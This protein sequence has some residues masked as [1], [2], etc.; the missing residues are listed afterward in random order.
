MQDLNPDQT[1]CFLQKKNLNHW[2]K[3]KK[4]IVVAKLVTYSQKKKLVTV[5]ASVHGLKVFRLSS[6]D[7]DSNSMTQIIRNL[8]AHVPQ[9]YDLQ[10][11]EES[12]SS[13]TQIVHPLIFS[14]T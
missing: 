11:H 10:N 13:S 14:R 6:P 3:K 8:M 2:G 7:L 9:F 4:I 5:V 1:R 12:F